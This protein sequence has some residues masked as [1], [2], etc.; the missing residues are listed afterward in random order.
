MAVNGYIIP[1]PMETQQC[2][3]ILPPD[4][5]HD[6]PR[7][8]GCK[9]S[10]QDLEQARRLSSQLMGQT[11]EEEV[12]TIRRIIRL[13]VCRNSHRKMFDNACQSESLGSLIEAYRESH[14]E[15]VTSKLQFAQTDEELFERY[16]P[17]GNGSTVGDI[18]PQAIN[19]QQDEEGSIYIFDWPR[20][21]GFLKI[22]Y[23]R[24]SAEKRTNTWQLCHSEAT[25]LYK[26]EFAFPERMEKL[27]HA[28]LAGKR[29]RLREDCSRCR[30]IHTEW[31][32]VTLEEAQRV[33]RNWHE[34]AAS[35]LYTEERTLSR[36][37]S[38]IVGNLSQ[39]TVST[40]CQYLKENPSSDMIKAR[41]LSEQPETSS[42]R[43]SGQT[44]NFV[45]SSSSA[46]DTQVDRQI[47]GL[48]VRFDQDLTISLAAIEYP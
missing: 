19:Q 47:D 3:K 9:T 28:E 40:L 24:A 21:P 31:F 5:K 39:V 35:P 10:S 2:I 8:C 20:T 33:L 48:V 29:Y 37:W 34:I 14:V 36:E 26:V 7:R 43:T 18:L 23:A 15:P 1:P 44:E 46:L 16:H 41:S 45:T 4:S 25:L 30:R 38:R 22:G 12:R 6:Q 32:A 42:P 11:G 27:I 13:C 17:T